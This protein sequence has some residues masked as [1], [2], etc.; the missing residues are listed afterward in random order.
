MWRHWLMRT[1]VFIFS[2]LSV[3]F[4]AAIGCSP[5]APPTA[6]E[7]VLTDSNQ[8]LNEDKW[9]LQAGD[10]QSYKGDAQ[11]KVE[12]HTL[13]GGKQDGVEIIEVDNGTLQFRVI[14]TRGMGILDV[15]LGDVRLGW[16]SP[17]KE[18]VHPL[19]LIHI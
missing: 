12:K 1:P 16:D 11:W 6:S 3:A 17:I 10:L 4:I 14:P 9:V 19:S 8:S 2:I 7:K 5:A 15:N 18:V 13:R